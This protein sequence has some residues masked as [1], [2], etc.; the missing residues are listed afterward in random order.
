VGDFYRCYVPWLHAAIG[1]DPIK[2]ILDIGCDNGVLTC[3]YANAFPD[4]QVLGVDRIPEGIRCATEL[5]QRVN[6]MNIQFRELNALELPSNLAGAKFDLITASMTYHSIFEIPNMPRGW[7]LAKLNL[8]NNSKWRDSLIGVA[9]SLA[10]SGRFVTVEKLT[11][12]ASVLWWANAIKG[13]G[14]N[15]NWVESELLCYK[16]RG[17]NSC[18]PALVCDRQERPDDDRLSHDCLAFSAGPALVEL[19]KQPFEGESAETLFEAFG[20]RRL[21]WGLEAVSVINNDYAERFEVWDARTVI[22]A[23]EYS[24]T[25][26]RRLVIAPFN[27]QQECIKSVRD[28]WQ[29]RDNARLRQYSSTSDRDSL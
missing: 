1:N 22:L 4:A 16:E 21:I 15:I 10:V 5:A 28:S 9:D 14:L 23:Y 13:A 26:K 24:N 12:S 25:G 8:P 11:S 19:A 27:K 2:T 17:E 6:L 18:Y 20:D 29:K 7:S 3:C